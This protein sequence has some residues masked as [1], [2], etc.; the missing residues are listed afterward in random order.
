MTEQGHSRWPATDQDADLLRSRLR[1][2]GD[3]LS[4][5]S[6][7]DDLERLADRVERGIRISECRRMTAQ[8]L[9]DWFNAGAPI[10]FFDGVWTK[11]ICIDFLVFTWKGAFCVWSV[12]HRWT[13]NQA[14]IVQ[15]AR[16]QIQAEMPGWGGKVEAVFHSPRQETGWDRH[17]MVH[18]LTDEPVEIVVMRGRIDEILF[19]WEPFD[20]IGLDP[21]WLDW[22]A[23]A[24]EPRWWRSAEGR[25]TTPPLMPPEE[26]L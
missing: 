18:P 10:M 24:V 19:H 17:V 1:W 4:R 21:E 9:S 5:F 25:I 7:P 23:R 22:M 16:V 6:R 8:M 12:D 15:P 20:G 26:E 3:G 13:V 2:P 14:A 11:G